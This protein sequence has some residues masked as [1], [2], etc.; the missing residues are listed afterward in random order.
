MWKTPRASSRHRRLGERVRRRFGRLPLRW[1]LALATF[2]LLAVLLAALG[3]LVSLTEE[4]ALLR[5]Q[6]TVLFDEARLASTP[7][8]TRGFSGRGQTPPPVVATPPPNIA[9][10]SQFIANRLTGLGTVATVLSPSGSMLAGGEDAVSG[11]LGVAS[12]PRP[13]AAEV[14]RTLHDRVSTDRYY[15]GYASDGSHWLYILLPVIQRASNGSLGTVAI[16]QLSERT[17]AIDHSVAALRL[18]LFTGIAG[19][20]L[21][22]GALALPLVG[23]AL[24]PLRD[25]E[26]TSQRISA[27]ALSL[28]LK[29]P[30]TDDEVGHLARSFNAMVARLEEAFLRQKRFVSDVSHELRTPLT[31]L[32]GQLEMLM[33]GAD[34]GDPETRHRLM[35]GMYAETERMRRLVE[36]LLT[37]ARLDEGRL[38]LR[39]APVDTA[40]IVRDVCE[41]AQTLAQG[42]VVSCDVPAGPL[43]AQA[44][45]DRLREVLLNLVENAVK[46]TPTEGT[47]TLA[48]HPGAARR[49]VALEVRDTGTGIPPEALPH[50]FDRFYRADFARVRA[51]Q[52]TSGSG[53]GLS[54]AKSLIEA[55][56]GI[57]AVASELGHGT[58]V[59]I[60][61]PSAPVRTLSPQ[62]DALTLT[63][64]SPSDAVTQPLASEGVAAHDSGQR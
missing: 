49:T 2:G 28:R 11:P 1:R 14:Q 35:R 47:I 5:N 25:M 60:T 36:D 34:A 57:I 8:S 32:G 54:I 50:V 4:Q 45:G 64:S 39:L 26:R 40:A 10:E 55:Q 44:D 17:S 63:G 16:L 7:T 29:E 58:T 62:H 6:A 53:L 56:G 61:L 20:L 18:I 46:F 3:S 59:T 27:G 52:S 31:A 12:L 51:P 30:E 33:L 48:A 37:L 42:Q 13:T 38:S 22:A 15:I 19:A 9:L 23:A 41:Q 21:L 24:R 43:M